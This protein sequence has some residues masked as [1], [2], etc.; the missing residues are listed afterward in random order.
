[1]TSLKLSSVSFRFSIT[2]LR[3][4]GRKSKVVPNQMS[5]SA[6]SPAP[7]PKLAEQKRLLFDCCH[8]DSALNALDVA[9]VSDTSMDAGYD[10]DELDR[11]LVA[12]T[13]RD[14]L[15]AHQGRLQREFSQ[16]M[17][18]ETGADPAADTHCLYRSFTLPK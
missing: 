5:D 8:S 10:D 6:L 16:L 3:R 18:L 4:K 14:E 15:E 13:P 11:T 1:M 12:A 2:S 9:D 17:R 7:Q